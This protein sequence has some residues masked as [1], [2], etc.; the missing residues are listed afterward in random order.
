MQNSLRFENLL[1]D[2]LVYF[3]CDFAYRL[4]GKRSSLEKADQIRTNNSNFK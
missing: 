2:D 3:L 1:S 4:M